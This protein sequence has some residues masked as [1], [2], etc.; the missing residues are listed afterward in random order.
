MIDTPEKQAE[1]LRPNQDH[2]GRNAWWVFGGITTGV[3]LLLSA[4][5]AGAWIWT[6]SSPEQSD[7]YN[8]EFAQPVAGIDVTVEIGEIQ[9]NASD[10]AALVVERETRWR[11][12]EPEPD[13]V[14]QS[15]TYVAVGDCDEDLV[16]WWDGD[17]CEVDYT[18]A[19]PSGTA[20]E[21][22]NSV[23]DVRLNGL[24]G[25]IDVETSVGSIEGDDLRATDTTVQS[26]VGSIRLDF[27]EVRGDISVIT[28]TGDVEIVV[29]DDGTTYDVQFASGVGSQDIDI[30]TDAETRADYVINVST[31]VG[32][33]RVRYAD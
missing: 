3:V 23:G 26:S 22:H 29:P 1:A 24:D 2:T 30:A 12:N 17:E 11:G 31:G 21:A 27:A 6:T 13:E 32:D 5:V 10:S 9:L 25:V 7:T 8:E 4:T 16:F 19:L 14:W 28:S 15:D 20:A 33:L 18:L